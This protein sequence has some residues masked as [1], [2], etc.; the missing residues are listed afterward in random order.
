M[1]LPRKFASQ[2][3]FELAY[4][5]VVLGSNK[6]YKQY[7]RHYFSSYNLAVAENC[8]E[9][10]RDITAG[11]YH[12]DEPSVVFQPK[13]SGILRPLT[14]L[15][16]RDQI[17]YQAIA[18]F[19]A[20]KMR[21][22]QDKHALK[23]NFG[24]ITSDESSQYFFRPWRATYRV[25]NNAIARHFHSGHDYVADFDLVSCYEL[26]DHSLLR[27][28][29]A[30]RVRNPELLDLLFRCL[31]VW[32]T[33]HSGRH[34]R[35]GLPQGPEAS[36]FLAECLLYRFDNIKF[37]DVQY[38][39]YVDDIKL[40]AKGDLPLRRALLKL[41]LGSKDLGLVPQ[42]QKIN[43]GKVESV[44]EITKLIPSAIAAAANGPKGADP[45]EMYKLF[46][47]SMRKEGKE[48]VVVDPTK[49]KFSILR[50]NPRKDGLR[51]I[52]P[53]LV[54]RPDLCWFL[55]AYLKKF[56]R[57]SDA[58][59][60]LLSALQADPT[61]DMAAANF[62]D[63]LD[64]CEPVSYRN[65]CLRVVRS[66]SKRSEEHTILL[67]MATLS[68]QA[69]REGSKAAVVLIEKEADPRVRAVAIHRLFGDHD[70]ACFKAEDCADLL[71]KEVG[72][73][74]G[75]LARFCAYLLLQ[76]A[77]STG[78]TWDLP[79]NVHPAVEIMMVSLG[80]RSR[81]PQ[82][83]SVL[84]AFF[85]SHGIPASFLWRK[86][87]R[88]DFRDAEKR[89][90]RL[91]QLAHGDPTA[92]VM[93]LD[94]FNEVL[95]Q[96]LSRMHPMLRTAYRTASGAHPHPDYGNWLENGTFRGLFPDASAL[97]LQIH[98][99]RVKADLAHAK[100]K[101]GSLKGRPTRPISYRQATLLES[102]VPRAWIALIQEWDSI[103]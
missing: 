48:W 25:Y 5:R 51:R 56:S 45:R 9:V 24:P 46:R 102:N 10:L 11:T 100:S 1:A 59:D 91:Q 33:N 2:K 13:R 101:R 18:N 37:R 93:M 54:R 62:I 30:R 27:A 42:A 82:R 68:F 3:N 52:S 8:R 47:Q 97:L 17:V 12:P 28:T 78:T 63:A 16:L 65:K 95:V 32:T 81:R 57:K 72:G 31:S 21:P 36:A 53:L 41:D 83:P 39:R 71:K 77:I 86:A 26:I 44:E 40:M 7:Y 61:H 88:S 69:R 58:A 80:L 74:D 34:L 29:L 87:L 60:V 49:F 84:P 4:R 19:I 14:L 15:S 55:A 98:K 35:H 92:R 76:H 75:D 50:L 22:D 99:A 79:R 6:D 38:L 89:C 66:A 73:A 96:A 70:G 20:I 90:L 67:R 103:L 85:A 64:A 43:L 23:R 94:T